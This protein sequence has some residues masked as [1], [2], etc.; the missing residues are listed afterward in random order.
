V[1]ELRFACCV[2]RCFFFFVGEHF[3]NIDELSL[4]TVATTLYSN[5]TS[6]LQKLCD[7]DKGRERTA[8]QTF[9]GGGMMMVVAVN[10]VFAAR[11]SS[12]CRCI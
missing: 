6:L 5:R 7:P 4:Q 10:E 9:G 3:V 1:V 8:A 2:E 12:L 11:Q